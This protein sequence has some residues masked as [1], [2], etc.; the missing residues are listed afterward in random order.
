[1]NDDQLKKIKALES[2]VDKIKID[3][4]SLTD[5]V[6]DLNETVNNNDYKTIR[7]E[8]EITFLIEKSRE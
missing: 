4:T 7:M 6:T 8:E 5:L 1:M 3:I 2:D